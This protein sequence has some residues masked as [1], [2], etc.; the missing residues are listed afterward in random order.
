LDRSQ[1]SVKR[2]GLT[3]FGKDLGLGI[4]DVG[5]AFWR[6]KN[7]GPVLSSCFIYGDSGPSNKVGE[8]SVQLASALGINS[9]PVSGGIDSSTIGQLKKGIVHI[10]FPG[11]GKDSLKKGPRLMSSLVPD[12]IETR[13]KQ[14][15]ASFLRRILPQRSLP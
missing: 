2:P 5:I 7:K 11:S 4:G 10:A 12:Q 8:G 9:D 15:F 1:S 14:L 13:A 6:A 3:D